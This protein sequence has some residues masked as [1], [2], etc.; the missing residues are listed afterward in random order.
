MNNRPVPRGWDLIY[1]YRRGCMVYRN[2]RAGHTQ[3]QRPEPDR[4]YDEFNSAHNLYSTTLVHSGGSNAGSSSHYTGESQLFPETSSYLSGGR[5]QTQY[6]NPTYVFQ[7]QQRPVHNVTQK[8]WE[9]IRAEIPDVQFEQQQ[10]THRHHVYNAY[11]HDQASHEHHEEYAQPQYRANNQYEGPSQQHYVPPND[12]QSGQSA[13][14]ASQ[15]WSMKS[16]TTTATGDARFDSHLYKLFALGGGTNEGAGNAPMCN[17]E[18][19]KLIFEMPVVLSLTWTI[20]GFLC[21]LHKNAEDS[22]SST[23]T[24]E[25]PVLKVFKQPDVHKRPDIMYRVSNGS[26]NVYELRI[27]QAM[28]KTK[29]CFISEPGEEGRPIVHLVRKWDLVKKHPIKVVLSKETY[30][31]D[32]CR[33]IPLD[34]HYMTVIRVNGMGGTGRP[35]YSM[36]EQMPKRPV[37]TLSNTDVEF[38]REMIVAPRVNIA[39]LVLIIA[40]A[41]AMWNIDTRTDLSDDYRAEGR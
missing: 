9:E 40:G 31:H 32:D 22:R 35:G 23:R 11:Q 7:R 14:N 28:K 4:F 12:E 15:A 39:L 2:K 29:E 20:Y 24:E 8:Y 25:L 19:K 21:R 34:Q 5:Q 17:K 27:R 10:P 30:T 13:D 26:R 3:R 33:E 38:V 37:G 1:D 6:K 16:V 18:A 36:T 41:D